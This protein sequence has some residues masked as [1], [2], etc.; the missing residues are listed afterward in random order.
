MPYRSNIVQETAKNGYFRRVVHTGK[1]SQLVV[2]CVPPGG[3]IGEETHVHVEQSLFF[4]SGIG[5]GALDGKTFPIGPGDVVVVTPGVRHNF[6][7]T[8]TEPLRIFTVYA[9]PNHIDGRIH[10]TKADADADEA[11]EAF[12]HIPA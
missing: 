12:V 9:P 8:G 5:E 6:V 7:N 1:N 3:E 10:K 4:Q 11:D 2:M